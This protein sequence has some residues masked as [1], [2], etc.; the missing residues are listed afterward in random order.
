MLIASLGV[1][2][3]LTFV[4]GLGAVCLWALKRWGLGSLSATVRLPVE[5]VQR[6]PLG[7]KTGLTVVR[8]GEKVVA[9]AVGEGG[10]T[11]LFELDERDRQQVVASSAVPVPHR[12]SAQAAAAYRPLVPASLAGPFGRLLGQ[13]LRSEAGPAH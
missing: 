6:V 9:L 1:I 8:V 11:T 2:A 13:Q 4:L 12:S 5:V 10:V 7:P 3:A